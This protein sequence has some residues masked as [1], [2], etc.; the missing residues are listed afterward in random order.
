[1]VPLV[2]FFIFLFIIRH[3]FQ[4]TWID[5]STKIFYAGVILLLG[6]MVGKIGDYLRMPIQINNQEINTRQRR[7]SIVGRRR[8]I[9]GL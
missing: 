9:V 1:M 2:I 6:A 3:E 7:R 4:M 5:I 8:S